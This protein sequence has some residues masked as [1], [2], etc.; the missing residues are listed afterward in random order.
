MKI[1]FSRLSIGGPVVTRGKSKKLRDMR[2]L[3]CMF[4]AAT[5]VIMICT[6]AGASS[7]QKL[8]SSPEEAVNSLVEAVKK[9]DTGQ[10]M[11]IFGKAGRELIIS[12]DPTVD[13]EERSLFLKAYQE[14]SRLEEVSGRKYILHV[15]TNDWPMPIPIIK[16]GRTWR[17]DTKEGRDEILA[18]RIG[19]NEFSAIQ[20][21]LAYADAQRE[22][23]I[24]HMNAGSVE[25][26]RQFT[27]D[28]GKEN[29]LCREEENAGSSSGRMGPLIAAA[30]PSE[31][32]STDL[33]EAVPYHGYF[34]KILT[35]QGKNAPG[36]TYNYIINGKMIGGFALVAYPA[37]YRST[38]VKTF[39]INHD[40][41][42]Y[43]KDLGKK[44]SAIAGNMTLFDPDKTWKPV[45]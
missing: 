21:C 9:N 28:P 11:A 31:T 40:G 4:F 45:E 5:M 12:G 3:A 26:A 44:T 32:H 23:A 34:Y 8:F 36:G 38:G 24:D 43:E 2:W 1:K 25:Y 14:M 27:A 20:V 41:T 30:C 37:R 16:T 6:N 35:G 10:L 42:V 19:R 39:I 7:N 29:G 33:R 15:G 22:Y 18:R 13:A 17:F